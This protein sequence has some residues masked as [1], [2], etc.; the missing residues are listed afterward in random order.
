MHSRFLK[1]TTN[2]WYVTTDQFKP[3]PIHTYDADVTLGRG[4]ELTIRPTYVL[5]TD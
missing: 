1:L 4:N 3:I 2:H 5:A